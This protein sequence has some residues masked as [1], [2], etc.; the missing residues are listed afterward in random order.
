MDRLSLPLGWQRRSSPDRS[1][2]RFRLDDA[3]NHHKRC[4]GTT[5]ANGTADVWTRSAQVFHPHTP[6]RREERF[7][8]LT[9]A[10]FLSRFRTVV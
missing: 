3:K 4:T 9:D 1:N 2:R 6:R 10:W 7:R 5:E 8:M